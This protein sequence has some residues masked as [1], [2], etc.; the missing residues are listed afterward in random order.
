MKILTL[1]GKYS[2][3]IYNIS[4]KNFKFGTAI[5]IIKKNNSMNYYLDNDKKLAE[6]ILKSNDGLL[7][8]NFIIKRS[9]YE[10]EELQFDTVLSKII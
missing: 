2:N 1:R 4:T 7:A 5:D 8:W 9:N 3:I 10:Y 6:S